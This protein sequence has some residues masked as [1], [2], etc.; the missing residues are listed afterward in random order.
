MI[1]TMIQGIFFQVILPAVFIATLWGGIKKSKLDW[2]VQSLFTTFYISWLFMTA[3]WDFL[4]YYLRYIWV[5][6]L[7]GALILSYLKVRRKPFRA[8]FEKGEKW[9]FALNLFLAGVF[10]LYNVLA[11]SG[12]WTDE[13]AIELEFPLKEG[14]YYIGQGGA[15]VQVNYHHAYESQQYAIDIV[16]L[17]KWGVRATG[18]YPGENSKYRIYGDG[19]YSPCTGEVLEAEEK[20]PDLSPPQ[21]NPE[22][23]AG[24]H[25]TLQCEDADARVLIAHMQ[26]DSL[27]VEEG[28]QVKAGEKLG[29]VGNSG[30][31]SEPH[32]HIHAEKDGVGIPIKF[33]GRF[34]VR[35]D[36][37]W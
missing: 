20:L 27:T 34:L 28:D 26:Q 23:A 7:I 24:N 32:V 25:V 31:T 15:H 30:N 13:K 18:I 4:T 29:L 16:K 37:V 17:D 36:L 1:V 11:I 35:N 3:P 9:S 21:T 14:V 5:L 6:L 19:V 10:G 8:P 33:N 2:L 22:K 12:L